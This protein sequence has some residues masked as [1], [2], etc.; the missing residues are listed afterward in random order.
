MGRCHRLFEHDGNLYLTDLH[1]SC[2][3]D[4][5]ERNESPCTIR[6]TSSD[7]QYQPQLKLTWIDMGLPCA[8]S[9]WLDPGTFPPTIE[10]LSAECLVI[11]CWMAWG[12]SSSFVK[13]VLLI[14]ELLTTSMPISMIICRLI[15]QCEILDQRPQVFTTIAGSSGCHPSLSVLPLLPWSQCTK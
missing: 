15:S 8:S 5:R 1:S 12:R 7:L 14:S 4:V 6:S 2:F 9:H 11:G 3:R 10:I 13:L